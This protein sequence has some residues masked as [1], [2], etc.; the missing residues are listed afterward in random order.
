[1]KPQFYKAADVPFSSCHSSKKQAITGII[2]TANKLFGRKWKFD[3]EDENYIDLD[4]SPHVKHI[5][6]I[7]K[8]IYVL[9]I[10]CIVEEMM[11]SEDVL[12]T[13]HSDSS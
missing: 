7:G 3:G 4:T 13:Y 12:V 6:D 9:S 5:H 2:T 1:M 10:K 11:A 8:S